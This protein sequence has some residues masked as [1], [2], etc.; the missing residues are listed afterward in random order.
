MAAVIGTVPALLVGGLGSMIVAAVCW[1]A[2]PQLAKVG[3]FDQE[4]GPPSR[5]ALIIFPIAEF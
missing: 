2:F 5:I 1:K 4:L 3:R